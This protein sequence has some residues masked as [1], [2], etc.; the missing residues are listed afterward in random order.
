MPRFLRPAPPA[1]EQIVEPNEVARLFSHYRL[2]ILIWSTIGY[3]GYYF[4]RKNLS[5]AMPELR[6]I[7]HISKT[8]LGN[9]L[10]LHGVAYGVAKFAN[11]FLGDRANAP[12]FMALGLILSAGMNLGFGLSSTTTAMGIFWLF[13]GWFQGMGYP[14]CARLMTH[15]FPPNILTSRMALWN[16]SHSLGAAGVVILCG[17]L[18]PHLGWQS[19]FFVPA[20]LATIVACLLLAFLR[21]TPESVG[22][23][24]VA[25]HSS[26]ETETAFR[27][28]LMTKVFCNPYIWLFSLANFFVYTIRYGVLDWGPTL[29]KESKGIEI[30]HGSWMVAGFE[31][32]GLA[33]IV[34]TGWIT[35]RFF[36]GRGSRMCIV[37]MALS[38]VAVFFF[39]RAPAGNVW[40]NTMLMMFAGFFIYAPQALI[41]AMAAN[42]GTKRAAASAVGLTSLF[43]YVSTVISGRGLG[44]LAD[45]YGWDAGFIALL[46]AA[47]VG[48]LLFAATWPAKA[49]GY[50]ETHTPHAAQDS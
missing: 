13:N 14:P 16:T 17:Y 28:V 32:A 23:P 46:I 41:G 27:T 34:L 1:G 8:D 24:E 49:H 33:G 38:G 4:V 37:C 35:D 6:D 26:R 43:G 31:I 20:I 36:G 2:R 39:W 48:T 30:R 5:V 44:Q 15:W 25:G 19:C 12:K 22:L 29:L 47:G 7:L 11:G 45:R 9:I 42:L 18:V 40:L 3:A 21:D 50:D 10:T